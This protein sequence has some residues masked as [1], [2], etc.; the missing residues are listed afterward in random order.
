MFNKRETV[1]K[2]SLSFCVPVY[3]YTCV[4]TYG[5]G[6]LDG[7]IPTFDVVV[8]VAELLPFGVGV[9]VPPFGVGVTVPPLDVEVTVPPLG[10][11]VGVTI[12]LRCF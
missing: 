11:F 9:V 5:V 1:K 4:P 10:V 6:V 7:V 12:F 3:L 8:T 2:N